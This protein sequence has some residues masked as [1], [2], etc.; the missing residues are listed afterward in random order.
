MN[1]SCFVSFE[2]KPESHIE[3]KGILIR[4]K[5]G[6]IQQLRGPNFDHRAGMSDGVPTS[7]KIKVIEGVAFYDFISNWRNSIGY[8]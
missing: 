5:S 7:L 4:I 3:V 8:L 2:K 1:S 6:V